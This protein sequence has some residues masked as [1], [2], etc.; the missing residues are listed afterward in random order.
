MQPLNDATDLT[1]L[2]KLFLKVHMFWEGHKILR[3]LQQL[4][5]RLWHIWSQTQMVL[6]IWSPTIGPQLIGPQLIGPSGQ[7]VP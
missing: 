5:V 1:N 2:T 4:F 7:T 6:D 3:N